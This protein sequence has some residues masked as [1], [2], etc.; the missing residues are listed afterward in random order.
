M[1]SI[2]YQKIQKTE[3]QIWLSCFYRVVTN[4]EA[5]VQKFAYEGIMK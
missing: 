5:T 4:T 3:G 1:L 2:G